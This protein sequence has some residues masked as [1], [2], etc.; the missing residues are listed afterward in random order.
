MKYRKLD[1]VGFAYGEI[2]DV[3]FCT[4]ILDINGKEIY[5]NDIV[6]CEYSDGEIRLCHVKFSTAF[7]Q[8][9]LD[10]W[11]VMTRIGGMTAEGR[12][13]TKIG[14]AYFHAES[15]DKINELMAVAPKTQEELAERTAKIEA[16]CIEMQTPRS[17]KQLLGQS[18]NQDQVS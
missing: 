4:G 9:E 18:D 6:L 2:E 17:Y 7:Y 15:I 16:I 1:G 10:G 13:Y 14:N 12:K 11:D 3:D 8:E 5:A